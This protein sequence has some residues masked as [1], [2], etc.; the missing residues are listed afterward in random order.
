M[1]AMTGK[2]ENKSGVPRNILDHFRFK[3]EV[4][5]RPR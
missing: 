5:R 4:H 2:K 1:F 3:T